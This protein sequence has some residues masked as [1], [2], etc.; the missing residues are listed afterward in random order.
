MNEI[1]PQQAVVVAVTHPAQKRIRIR[2]RLIL[3]PKLAA[4]ISPNN[5]AFNG[6]INKI[7]NNKPITVKPTK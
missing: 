2:V 1:G 4:Y 7:D 3:I 6:F 5:N